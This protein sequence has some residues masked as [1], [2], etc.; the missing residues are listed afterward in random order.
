MRLDAGHILGKASAMTNKNRSSRKGA[1][2]AIALLAS[3]AVLGAPPAV[4]QM[5]GGP[6]MSWQMSSGLVDEVEIRITN[7]HNALGVTADQE[8]LFRTYAD[9]MR[10]N[11]RTM[12]GLFQQRAQVT[13]FTASARLRW[14][15]QLTAAH[16]TA[17][18]NLIAPFDALYQTL[19]DSQKQA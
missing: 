9:A 11:A 2:G 7:L 16:A 14:Y 17:V 13:D 10:A 1:L 3:A 8:P 15:A 5:H 19:S 12:Q 18:N 4:A 6:M